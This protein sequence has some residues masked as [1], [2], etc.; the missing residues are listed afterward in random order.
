MNESLKEPLKES[1]DEPREK[2]LD[3]PAVNHRSKLLRDGLVL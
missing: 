1:P 3:E 2:P